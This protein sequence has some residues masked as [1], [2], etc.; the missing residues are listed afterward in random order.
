MI[1]GSYEIKADGEN[2][3]VYKL[4]KNKHGEVTS[5]AVAYTRDV[6]GALQSIQRK[7]SVDTFAKATTATRMMKLLKTQQEELLTTVKENCKECLR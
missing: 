5:T 2:T 6:L 1:I 3:A 4:G 7:M